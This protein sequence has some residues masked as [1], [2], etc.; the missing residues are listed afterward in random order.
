MKFSLLSAALAL[1]FA[2]TASA[3]TLDQYLWEKRPI[4]VFADTP[5]DLLFIRQME[6]LNA[7]QEELA[8]RDVVILTDTDSA[9]ISPLRK[10]LRPRGFQLALI[11]KDGKVIS[12]YLLRSKAKTVE[13]IQLHVAKTQGTSKTNNDGILGGAY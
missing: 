4:V 11:G 9:E 3:E 5:E 6:L 2:T 8:E 7:G 10:K 1:T 12:G 13:T